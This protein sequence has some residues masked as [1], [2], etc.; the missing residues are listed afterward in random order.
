VE[1]GL[2][3]RPNILIRRPSDLLVGSMVGGGSSKSAG[4]TKLMRLARI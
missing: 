1:S 3:S 4:S 2:L